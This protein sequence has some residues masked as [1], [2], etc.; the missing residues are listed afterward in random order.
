MSGLYITKRL[1]FYLPL[2]LTPQRGGENIN[3]QDLV[4][5]IESYG[6]MDCLHSS[7]TFLID[8]FGNKYV[9]KQIKLL[10]DSNVFD[11]AQLVCEMVALD[12]GH[13]IEAPLNYA[14]LIPAGVP[15]IGKL[16]DLPAT[17]HTYARGVR[18]DKYQGTQYKGLHIR[19][20]NAQNKITGLTR[21]IIYH[22]SRH[23]DLPVLVALDTFVG[24]GDR[25]RWNYF[26]DLA[27]DSFIGI[28]MADAFN[29]KLCALSTEN[30]YTL[31]FNEQV[32][33]S[34]QEFQGL[35]LYYETLHRLVTLYPPR[36]IWDKFEMYI[37]LSGFYDTTF[38]DQETMKNC[39]KFF[40]WCNQIMLANYEHA[41]ELDRLL[42]SLLT[43][44]GFLS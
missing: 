29:R 41:I 11:P 4:T 43:R 14:A 38:F 21:E 42:K 39:F 7:I 23:N 28:D 27:T 9:V 2:M 6:H 3:Y 8:P 12:I 18:F 17:L 25:G 22:M 35:L 40:A 15:F 44:K 16:I 30:M 32:D 33:F 34:E 26:Y 13:S 1:A 24:N 31:F 36:A 37:R 5:E 20:R 10:R 19:Q